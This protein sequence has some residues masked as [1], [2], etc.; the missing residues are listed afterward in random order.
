M[1]ETQTYV[2]RRLTVHI[3]LYKQTVLLRNNNYT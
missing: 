1:D 2:A 3:S